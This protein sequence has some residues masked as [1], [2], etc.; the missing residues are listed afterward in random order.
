MSQFEAN[1]VYLE[2]FSFTLDCLALSCFRQIYPNNHTK[3]VK[4][5]EKKGIIK[6]TIYVN[7]RKLK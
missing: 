6:M 5:I 3:K 1:P 2:H 4:I 7:Y